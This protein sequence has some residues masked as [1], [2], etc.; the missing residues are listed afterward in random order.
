M[1]FEVLRYVTIDQ[2]N[3]A[4]MRAFRLQVKRRLYTQFIED[5]ELMS[6]ARRKA[7]LQERYQAQIE[8]YAPIATRIFNI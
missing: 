7:F 6:E 2:T 1:C 4:E 3:D 5:V 8:L